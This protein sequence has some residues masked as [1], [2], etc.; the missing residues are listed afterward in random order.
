MT[1]TTLGCAGPIHDTYN[2]ETSNVLTGTTTMKLALVL[3]LIAISLAAC[4]QEAQEAP[5][6]P[7]EIDHSIIP[8]DLA[9]QAIQIRESALQD[10]LS[11]DIVESL[12]TE[13]G[14][15]R[16]GT[17]GDQ[18]AVAWALA[19]F[20]ELG[21]DRAW[22]EEIV[23]D[24]GWIRGEAHAEVI[25]PYPQDLVIT[26]LGY[27]VGTGGDL[28]GEIVEFPTFDDL[29][30]VPE[31]DS[32]SGKIAFVSFNMASYEPPP[33]AGRIS[34]YG[35]ATCGGDCNSLCGHQ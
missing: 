8:E 33:G 31:G 27:S 17:P 16:V 32:L 5:P 14:A 26:A 12:T 3:P 19:K 13:V 4:T 2:M 18:R 7:L 35:Q 1:E 29:L 21:F 11:V 9:N 34:G 20:E 22:T 28:V 6:D 25:A 23:I 24:H 10:N 30:A 15:R